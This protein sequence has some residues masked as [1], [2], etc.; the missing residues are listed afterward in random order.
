[1]LSPEVKE[2]IAQKKAAALLKSQQRIG[3]V[4]GTVH[5]GDAVAVIVPVSPTGAGDVILGGGV[6]AAASVVIPYDHAAQTTFTSE[7]TL[8]SQLSSGSSSASSHSGDVENANSPK[9]P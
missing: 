3:S 1:M 6:A 7:T 9:R 4:T 2:K 5:A 8:S